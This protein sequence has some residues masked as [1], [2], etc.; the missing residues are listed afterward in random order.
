MALAQ[1][2]WAAS[3][4]PGLLTYGGPDTL[5][6]YYGVDL[7]TWA[8]VAGERTAA[9]QVLEA[10]LHWR[11]ASGGAGELFTRSTGD[12]GRNLP[13]HATSAAALVTLV[14]Q[15]LVFDDGDTL[16]LTLGARPAWWRGGRV[17]RAP[18][19]WG[20]LDLEFRHEG[21][22][23]QW[24]WT[25]VAVWTALELPPGTRLAAEPAAP[26]IRAG[27]TRVLAPPGTRSARVSIAAVGRPG[28]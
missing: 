28:L 13:P 7:A 9:D 12:F 22:R 14:H 17:R 24:T 10:M 19:C 8:L 2:V 6:Y 5:Q 4:G 25:A 3:G 18:T 23:A 16:M 11:T 26:L 15:A 21:D 20:E 27:A 1:R